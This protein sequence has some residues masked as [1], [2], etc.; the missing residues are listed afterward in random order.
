MNR[1]H[2]IHGEY[3]LT[4]RGKNGHSAT[5]EYLPTCHQR[6][7]WCAKVYDHGTRHEIKEHF[8]RYYF[9]D[10]H[11]QIEI[12]AWFV[13]N[14]VS[15]GDDWT[16]TTFKT[17]AMKKTT[18]KT[19]KFGPL[20]I[21]IRQYRET[22]NP[23]VMITDGYEPFA[24]LS[25]NIPE[26]HYDLEEYQFFAKVH[27]ENQEIAQEMLQSRHFRDTGMTEDLGHTTARVWEIISDELKTQWKEILCTT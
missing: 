13:R 25:V 3:W 14:E 7:N 10:K 4:L 8:P 15:L 21:E 20:D 5:I 22:G 6:G 11:A 17:E 12:E 16:V 19:K 2:M 26:A 24:T 27:S 23:A 18:V 9:F 1:I